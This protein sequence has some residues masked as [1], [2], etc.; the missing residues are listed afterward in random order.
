[1]YP[2]GFPL[3][4]TFVKAAACV[5]ASFA[6]IGT[7][8]LAAEAVPT[9][10][11]TVAYVYVS[12]TPA[13]ASSNKITGFAAAANGALT[14]LSGSPYLANVSAMA[15]NGSYLF[16]SEMSGNWVSSFSIHSNGSLHWVNSTNVQTPDE[17]GCVY[18]SG[19]SLDHS[20][21][22]LY[23]M[24]FTGGLCDHSHYQSFMIDKLSG[25][26]HFIGKSADIFLFDSPLSFSGS[27]K[28]AYGSQCINFEGSPLDTFTGYI[29]HTGGL[30]DVAGI[31]AP[32]PTPQDSSHFYCRAW[33]A[34]DPTSHLAVTFTD[35]NFDD[36]FNSPATQLGVYTIQPTGNLTTTSTWSNMPATDV[37]Y[38]TGLAMSRNGRLLAVSGMVGLQVF[39]FNGASPITHDTGLLTTDPINSIFWDHNHHLYAL[40]NS[41]GKLYVF[42]VVGSTV[43]AAPGSPHIISSPAGLI[44]QPLTDSDGDWDHD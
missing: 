13:G 30:L 3:Q 33:T 2:S 18:P 28:F 15:V 6:A 31:S 9:G 44:V 41:T 1:M 22:T 4:S 11:T 23:R 20:G 19:I 40:S 25:K 35:T 16:G 8:L 27:N 24:Q 12:Y 42:T 29:R 17:T 34:A 14:A 7:Q 43:T 38:T 37:G 10:S 5:V 26:L 36:P 32:D 21:S 39:F